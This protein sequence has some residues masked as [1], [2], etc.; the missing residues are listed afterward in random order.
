M[1]DK[2]FSF[3]LFGFLFENLKGRFENF[4]RAD[5]QAACFDFFRWQL[6]VELCH[7]YQKKEKSRHNAAESEYL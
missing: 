4:H 3:R 7:G 6:V 1:Q 5:F 2:G